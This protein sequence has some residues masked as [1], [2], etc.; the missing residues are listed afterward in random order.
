MIDCKQHRRRRNHLKM[1]ISS[2]VW[3][4][5]LST[6]S[7]QMC[8]RH[9]SNPPYGTGTSTTQYL[10]SSIIPVIKRGVAVSSLELGI[11]KKEIV[12]LYLHSHQISTLSLLFSKAIISVPVPKKDDPRLKRACNIVQRRCTVNSWSGDVLVAL[13]IPRICVIWHAG[14]FENRQFFILGK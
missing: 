10:T 1:F 2:F 4:W 8:P 11:Q 13:T 6:A 5:G 14:S 7:S 9:H 12:L 3:R